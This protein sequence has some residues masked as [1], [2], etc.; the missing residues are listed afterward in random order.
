MDHKAQDTG[1]DVRYG[2]QGRDIHQF[3][4]SQRSKDRRQKGVDF[5][6]TERD[7]DTRQGT[8]IKGDESEVCVTVWTKDVVCTVKCKGL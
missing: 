3:C 5:H 2:G 4:L 7:S 6:P 1:Q 8:G